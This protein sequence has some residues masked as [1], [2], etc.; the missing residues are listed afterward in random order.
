MDGW[1]DWMGG[2]A[3][4]AGCDRQC[5]GDTNGEEGLGWGWGWGFRCVVVWICHQ[6]AL[7]CLRSRVFQSI[8]ARLGT[9]V[10]L[11]R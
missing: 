5:G 11:V 6:F 2:A 8:F 9:W 10:G 3:R 7:T 1:M 4:R